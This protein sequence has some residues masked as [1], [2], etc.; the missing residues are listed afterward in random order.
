MSGKF[1][2]KAVLVEYTNGKIFA[3]AE[4]SALVLLGLN[5]ETKAVIENC[6]P[7]KINSLQA[8]DK[9]VSYGGFNNLVTILD[10]DGQLALVS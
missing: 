6:L 9:Y 3:I 5:L 8:T 1:F 4:D 7:G 2:E 10:L